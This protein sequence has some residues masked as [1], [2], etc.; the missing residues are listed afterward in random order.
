MLRP[1]S[2]DYSTL[3]KRVA[4]ARGP[5]SAHQCALCSDQ[6]R[7]WSQIHGTDGTDPERHYRPLCV[8]CHRSYDM[9]PE[10]RTKIS[11]TKAA[12]S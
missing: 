2:T 1:G 10:I 11:Q 3:H 6:A 12:V 8:S 5:A 9:T 7:E 4:V